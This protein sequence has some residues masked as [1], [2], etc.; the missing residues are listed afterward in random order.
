MASSFCLGVGDAPG[1]G[2]PE[3]EDLEET[4]DGGFVPAMDEGGGDGDEVVG[5][6]GDGVGEGET[7]GG[8]VEEDVGVGE[9]EV[10]GVGLAGGEGHG[11]G[12]AEPAC[13]EFRDVEGAESFRVLCCD[14]VDDFAGCVGAAVVDGDDLEVGVVLGEESVQRGGDVGGLVARGNDDG[15]GGRACG[16]DVVLR[17]EEVGDTWQADDGGDHLPEPEEGDEPGDELDCEDHAAGIGSPT[18]SG[19]A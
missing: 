16:G 6:G 19:G 8:G 11:V 14:A 17:G 5:V 12:F 7:D 9:E 3:A 4:E 13:G 10:V 18:W 1:A 15:D 2:R